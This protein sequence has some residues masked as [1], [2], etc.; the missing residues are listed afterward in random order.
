MRRAS[1]VIALVVLVASGCS[2]ERPAPLEP[3]APSTGAVPA[4]AT[5]N[6]FT[7]QVLNVLEGGTVTWTFGTRAHNVTFVQTAGAPQSIPTTTNNA[8]SRTFATPGTYAYACTLH[9]G[10]IGTVTVQPPAP[11]R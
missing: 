7:P 2:S 3:G 10:M 6:T 5:A 8:R 11:T 9:P 4:S 1:P